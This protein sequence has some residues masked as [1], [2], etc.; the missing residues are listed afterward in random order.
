VAPA[1]DVL[2]GQ[3]YHEAEASIMVPGDEFVSRVDQQTMVF[4]DLFVS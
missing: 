4:F 1:H 2:S 3:E